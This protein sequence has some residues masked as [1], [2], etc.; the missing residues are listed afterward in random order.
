MQTGKKKQLKHLAN[1]TL[2]P[3]GSI[4]QTSYR[5]KLPGAEM[6]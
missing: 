6:L 5:Q 2:M 3:H 1:L 4:T